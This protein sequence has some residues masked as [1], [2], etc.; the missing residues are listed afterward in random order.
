M[1]DREGREPLFLHLF[2]SADQGTRLLSYLDHLVLTVNL[3]VFL[4]ILSYSLTIFISNLLSISYLSPYLSL[5][6]IYL[7][8]FNLLS[9][10]QSISISYLSPYLS[11]SYLS[12][13]ISISFSLSASFFY[14]QSLSHL[15][16]Y[17]SCYHIRLHT[18]LYYR[19]T[20]TR[21][22]C[23]S[24]SIYTSVSFTCPLTHSPLNSI[25]CNYTNFYI[26][27]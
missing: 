21:F 25:A 6:L 1:E 7:P 9:I 5:S 3:S 11:I 23:I 4:S 15:I 10:C 12:A 8:I 18:C 24:F 13:Y 19:H 14:I 16:I 26:Y 27:R 20:S 17:P 2:A 22:L